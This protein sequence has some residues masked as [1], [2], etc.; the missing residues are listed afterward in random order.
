M[1]D[2]R[3]SSNIGIDFVSPFSS[4]NNFKLPAIQ[5]KKGK[6]NMVLAAVLFLV[7]GLSPT[8][9]FAVPIT[10]LFTAVTDFSTAGG[11]GSDEVRLT[12]TYSDD[13]PNLSTSPNLGR[14][15]PI[16]GNIRIDSLGFDFDFDT[17]NTERSHLAVNNDA[18]GF[19]PVTG[20]VD[21]FSI[22]VKSSDILMV[23]SD[24]FNTFGF[25]FIGNDSMLSDLSLPVTTDFFQELEAVSIRFGDDTFNPNQ[26]ASLT[27]LIISPNNASL[28]TVTSL[29]LPATFPLFAIGLFMMSLINR[30]GMRLKKN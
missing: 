19:F 22:F 18:T 2:A 4:G 21:L 6:S 30:Y 11:T 13:L 15:G 23:G 5:G 26:S 28:V 24:H 9:V 16:S 25:S 8:A 7:V 29:P 14:Y 20:I 10:N 12:Y 17:S 3:F 1:K 27:E